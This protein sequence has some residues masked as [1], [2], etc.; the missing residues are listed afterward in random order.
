MSKIGWI[1]T[2]TDDLIE[3][4]PDVPL[5]GPELELLLAAAHEAALAYAP[6]LP[7]GAPPPAS[8]KLAQIMLAKHLQA[9]KRAGEASS[10]GPDGLA[11]QTYPLVLEARSLL[12]PKRSPLAGLL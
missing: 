1:D 12:R 8:W 2:E 3:H 6:A 9:R 4:W 11:V 10:F 7:E 5:D